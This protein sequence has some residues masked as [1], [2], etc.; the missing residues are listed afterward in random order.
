MTE[1]TPEMARK[2]VDNFLDANKG[3]EYMCS[4]IA[5]EQTPENEDKG[6]FIFVTTFSKPRSVEPIPR[7][8]A[9]VTFYV[10]GDEAKCDLKYRVENETA[11]RSGNGSVGFSTQWVDSVIKRKLKMKEWF[12]CRSDFDMSR[13]KDIKEQ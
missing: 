6:E 9:K 11:V 13:W 12:D 7:A 10:S 8:V 5:K 1:M 3:S 2:H 4:T